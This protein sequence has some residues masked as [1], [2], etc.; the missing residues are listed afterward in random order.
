MA[1]S[2]SSIS[3]TNL[4]ATTLDPLVHPVFI[5]TMRSLTFSG[6]RAD[7]MQQ[8]PCKTVDEITYPP[9]RVALTNVMDGYE[10]VVFSH[11]DKVTN[12]DKVFYN[13]RFP[14]NLPIMKPTPTFL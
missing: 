9:A 12:K 8:L 10:S 13:S 3:G 2:F 14:L 7:T 6:G 5:P 4:Q 1:S 11:G